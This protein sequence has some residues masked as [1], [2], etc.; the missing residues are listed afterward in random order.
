[1][2]KAEIDRILHDALQR[3]HWGDDSACFK[4][5]QKLVEISQYDRNLSLVIQ[6]EPL[7]NTLVNTLKMFATS[8]LPASMCIVEISEEMLYFAN[9]QNQIAR[10]KIGVMC[11]SLLHAQVRLTAVAAQCL[12]GPAQSAYLQTQNELLKLIV[13]LL[14]NIAEAPS[15]VGKIVNKGIISPLAAVLKRTSAELIGL[16][17]L[18]IHKIANVS[19]NWRDV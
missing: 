3:I 16:A 9:Y 12:S 18:L 15:G 19:V 8:N 14:F 17:L 6:H 5:L 1:L 10:L 2:S 13:S 11:L 4:A 7:I